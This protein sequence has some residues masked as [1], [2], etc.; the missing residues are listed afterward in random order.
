MSAI[1]A[2]AI[3]ICALVALAI[4]A[5]FF[6]ARTPDAYVRAQNEAIRMQPTATAAALENQAKAVHDAIV[7]PAQATA[8]AASIL[9]NNKQRIDEDAHQQAMRH[10]GEMAALTVSNTQRLN[11][12]DAIYTARVEGIKA[13]SAKTVAESSA[14]AA[15]ASAGAWRDTITYGGIAIGAVILLV[16]CALGI[17]AWLSTRAKII[18]HP[19]TGPMLVTNRGVVLLANVTNP[20]IAWDNHQMLIAGENERALV[21]QRQAFGLIRSAMDSRQ[22]DIVHAAERAATS[23]IQQSWTPN[24]AVLDSAVQALPAG[25]DDLA[26]R[27]PTFAQMLQTWRPTVDQMIYGFD[28]NHQPVYGTLEQ[29]LSGLVI[30]RQGQGKT[31]LLRIL[32]LQCLMIRSDVIAWDIHDDIAEDI[33]G[34]VTYSRAADIERSANEMNAELERRIRLKLKREKVKPIMMLVD[35]VNEIVDQVPSLPKI[36][37]RIVSEGRKYR[38]FEF[39]TAKGAPADIFEKSWARDSFSALLA[40]WTSSLQA[41]NAGFESDVARQVETLKPGQALLRLQTAPAQVITFP[42]LPPDDM[43]RLISSPVSD[44]FPDD[45]QVVSPEIKN[46]LETNGNQA[47]ETEK[48]GLVRDLLLSG[49]KRSEIIEAVWGKTTGRGYQDASAELDDIMRR[50]VQ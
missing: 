39:V 45:F 11:E 42:D 40:F 32:Y 30:G 48:D 15:R 10:A 31:T 12:V 21:M 16:G 20:V 29:L 41:R 3:I 2:I 19:I 44:S 38:M 50:L 24:T 26:G 9:A 36:I 37:K 13:D 33:P 28:Q 47:P 46:T 7:V 49:K 22:P 8:E 43:Q 5:P 34:I 6:Q 25:R 27:V 23:T 18:N 35:E 4:L 17:V 14:D 1:K